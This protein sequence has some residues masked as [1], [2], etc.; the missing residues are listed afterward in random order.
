MVV[1]N[2]TQ[3][4]LSRQY[5]FLKVTEDTNHKTSRDMSFGNSHVQSLE[6]SLLQIVEI[7]YITGKCLSTEKTINTNTSY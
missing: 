7:F 2:A 1:N 3:K 4:K 6:S 5:D